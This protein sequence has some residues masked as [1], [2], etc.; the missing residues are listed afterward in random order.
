MSK[1]PNDLKSAINGAFELALAEVIDD[2]SDDV[3]E[4]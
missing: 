3:F 1:K 4:H 2:T